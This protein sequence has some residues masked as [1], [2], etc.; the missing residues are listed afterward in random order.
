[1]ERS[2]AFSLPDLLVWLVGMH[3]SF[4]VEPG[5]CPLPGKNKITHEREIMKSSVSFHN[6][7]MQTDPE[8]YPCHAPVWTQIWI[9]QA[10]L[11]FPIS[12]SGSTWKG[13]SVQAAVRTIQ[14]E[15]MLL[16]PRPEFIANAKNKKGCLR[17]PR[18][19]KSLPSEL[20][21]PTGERKRSPGQE[22]KAIS[23]THL[24]HTDS[25][26]WITDDNVN[27]PRLTIYKHIFPPHTQGGQ[28]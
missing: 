25:F 4:W 1:M 21:G 27:L 13:I 28:E 11:S 12:P 5:P 7:S 20:Q 26:L 16:C 17:Q 19:G 8:T 23:P 14:A 2:R 15:N 22:V 24:L 6:L 9:A 18:D 3:W 10:A